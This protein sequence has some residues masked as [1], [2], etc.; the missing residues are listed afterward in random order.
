MLK[1]F[2]MNPIPHSRPF[3]AQAE[4]NACCR[5]FASG[6]L[7]EGTEV[8]RLERELSGFV[9]HKYGIAVSS[10]TA[11]LYLALKALGVGKGDSVI[12]PSYVCTALLNAV[13]LAGAEPSVCDVDPCTGNMGL[14]HAKKVLRRNT[15]AAIVPHLFGQPAD[16]RAIERGLGVPVVEDCAQCVG[17]T[18]GNEK[19]GS[20]TRISIFSFYATKLI[21]AGEGGMVATSDKRLAEK[22]RDLREYDNRDTYI[23]AFNFKLSDIHAAIARAQLEKLPA[24]IRLR[25]KTAR[26]YAGMLDG[27]SSIKHLPEFNTQA[28]SVFFRFVAHI[29]KNVDSILKTTESAG[30][31][32]RKPIYKPLHQYLKK[33]GFPGTD[34]IYRQAISLPIYPGLTNRQVEYVAESFLSAI[35][36]KK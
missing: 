24:A 29:S 19:V 8:L 20:L 31:A 10:G 18:I 22:I 25:R 13:L 11:A 3:I 27:A 35:D 33:T 14:E 16:A 5:V 23:P 6:Q 34:E 26:A 28:P 15:R 7:S 2:F 12:I 32:C 36:R 30:V 21:C 1:T 9:G 17:T 4:K